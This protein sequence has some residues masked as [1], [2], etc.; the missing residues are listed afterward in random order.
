MMRIFFPYPI[1]MID[2]LSSFI[3]LAIVLFFLLTAIYSLKFMK[4]KKGLIQYY[5]YITLTAAASLGAIF[6]NNLILLV[7]C[8]GL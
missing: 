4:G 1:F 8:W 2:R 7:A 5:L 3:A 6:A